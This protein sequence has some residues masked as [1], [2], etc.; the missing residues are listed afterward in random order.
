MLNSY[1]VSF[2]LLAFLSLL[3]FLFQPLFFQRLCWGFFGFFFNISGLG[4]NFKFK[5]KN[6]IRLSIVKGEKEIVKKGQLDCQLS[7]G[8]KE[9][10]KIVILDL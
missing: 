7:K 3:L 9:I 10:V 4:H 1:G 2:L 5:L 6:T 8:E